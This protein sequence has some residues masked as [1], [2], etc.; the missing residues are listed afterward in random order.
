MPHTTKGR[1]YKST[2]AHPKPKTKMARR[3][4]TKSR[5]KARY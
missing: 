5:K 4:K 1:A 3:P 2:R